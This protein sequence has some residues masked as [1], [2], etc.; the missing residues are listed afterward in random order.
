MY[1]VL[2]LA[3]GNSFQVASF[4]LLPCLRFEQSC[5]L[6]LSDMP[7]EEKENA[8]KVSEVVKGKG[9]VQV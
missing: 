7:R 8:R 9:R 3:Q 5:I 6:L 2:L 1:S 4:V